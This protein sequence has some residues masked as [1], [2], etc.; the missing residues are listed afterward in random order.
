MTSCQ[1]SLGCFLIPLSLEW[2]LRISDWSRCF[3]ADPGCE[4][5]ACC[6]QRHHCFGSH[7]KKPHI[8]PFSQKDLVVNPLVITLQTYKSFAFCT[9]KQYAV[10]KTHYHEGSRRKDIF[11]ILEGQTTVEML[12]A[13]HWLVLFT[14]WTMA[15]RQQDERKVQQCTSVTPT[16]WAWDKRNERLK[17]VWATQWNPCKRDRKGGQRKEVWCKGTCL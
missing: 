17:T 12:S 3:S 10:F 8:P 11:Q 1:P 4:S 9:L 15:F 5:K 2:G 7:S 13:S 6:S 16:P 14:V